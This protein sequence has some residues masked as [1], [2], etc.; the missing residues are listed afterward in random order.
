MPKGGSSGATK[1][2]R[3]IPWPGMLLPFGL[4]LCDRC[5]VA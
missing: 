5:P 2:G 4:Q 1:V 3:G